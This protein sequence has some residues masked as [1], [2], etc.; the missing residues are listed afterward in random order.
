[1]NTVAISALLVDLIV[2]EPPKRAHP[3]VWMGNWISGARQRRQFRSN[4]ASVAEGAAVVAGGIALAVI[5]ATMLKRVVE[6]AP[7]ASRGALRALA[8][9]PAFSMRALVSAAH[10]IEGALA[11]GNLEEARRLLSWH[12]VSRDTSRLSE[13][14][15]AGAVIESVAENLSDSVVAPLLA[16]AAGGLPAAY[17]YRFINTADAMLGYRTPELEWFGKAAARTDDVANI[18]PA[19]VTAVLICLAAAAGAGSTK[20]GFRAALRD[21]RLTAS[22]N[23]GWP[24]AAMAGALDVRLTKRHHYAL[25]ANGGISVPDDITRCCRIALTVAVLAAL[26]VDT[27]AE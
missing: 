27:L 7:R 25:N 8:L 24:M 26:V 23:A 3:T 12:L 5:A 11:D 1:M 21:A 15:V 22:P 13:A 2:G 20:R 10:E 18:I 19:R 6:R 17:A 9:K 4:P 14:E 16:Y